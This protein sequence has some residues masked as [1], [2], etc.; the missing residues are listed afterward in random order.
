ME[1]LCTNVPVRVQVTILD[2]RSVTYVAAGREAS[3]GYVI[4]NACRSLQQ[5]R[6]RI[7]PHLDRAAVRLK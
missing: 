2:V 4:R 5:Y 6:D 3:G 1:R 7:L